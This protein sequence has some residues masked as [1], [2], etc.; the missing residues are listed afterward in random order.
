MGNIHTVNGRS[1]HRVHNA[2]PK[3]YKYMKRAYDQSGIDITILLPATIDTSKK[4]WNNAYIANNEQIYS[5][6]FLFD[7][8]AL[9]TFN[10]GDAIKLP[11]TYKFKQ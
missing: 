9:Y 8:G 10:R 7:D 4:F 11:K 5:V 1:E 3:T 2:A 6:S